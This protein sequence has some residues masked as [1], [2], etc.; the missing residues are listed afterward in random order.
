VCSVPATGGV[1]LAKLLEGPQTVEGE[2][3]TLGGFAAVANEG[4]GWTGTGFADMKG[5]EG[6]MTFL[7][8]VPAAGK[9]TLSWIYTQNDARDMRLTVDCTQKVESVAFENTKS[10][11]TDWISGGEQVV[12][13][14]KGTNM[15]VLETNGGSGPNFD[16]MTITPPVCVVADSGATLCEAEAALMTGAAGLA[17]AG[18]G[19]TGA[20]FA[21]MFGAEGVVNW[22]VD[23]PST[24][25]YKLTFR[26]TQADTRDMA[27][28]VN[29]VQVSASIPFNAT[30]SW[31]TNW[32]ADVFIDVDLEAG[33]NSVMLATNGA[34]GPNFDSVSIA[35]NDSGAGGAGAGGDSGTGGA[36]GAP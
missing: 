3:A 35:S 29:G 27:L 31:N 15:I 16:S 32:V 18:N 28:S 36:D 12:T 22:V 8:D 13:L 30:N 24:G 5:N 21:D 11:N 23:A 10:W 25:S 9:Y 4:S 34:S 19:W 26:Y 14:V 2:A 6:S 20:G 7:V 17:S 1:D 33:L